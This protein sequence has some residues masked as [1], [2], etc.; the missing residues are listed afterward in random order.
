MQRQKTIAKWLVIILL[1]TVAVGAYIMYDALY[2]GE[3]GGASADVGTEQPDPSPSEPETPDPDPPFYTE[4]P[5]PTQ[6]YAG[7]EVAHAGGEGDEAVLGAVFTA[8]REYVFFSSESEEYDCRGSG[9]YVAV[10]SEGALIAVTRFADAGSAFGGAKLTANGVAAAVSGEESGTLFLFD[11]SGGV[12]GEASVPLFESAFLLLAD[13][14]LTVFYSDGVRLGVC[15][16]GEGL[17]VDVSPFRLGGAYTV[18][19]GFAAGGSFVLAADNG[20]DVAV[21][22]YTHASGFINTKTYSQTSFKQ[23]VPVAGEDGAAFC[24]LGGRSDGVLLSVIGADGTEESAAVLEGSAD[25]ALFGDG[26]SLTLV[27]TGLTETYCRHLDLI[28]SVTTAF[29]VGDVLAVRESGGK[30]VILS[31]SEDGRATAWL[32]EDGGGFLS[33]AECDGGEGNA[34]A[35]FYGGSLALVLSSRS[36]DG[37]FFENFGGADAYFVRIPL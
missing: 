11:K 16:V 2:V 20:Q 5:R 34:A 21:I 23:I 4:L 27:R 31:R 28:S 35:E 36:R 33:V 7:I 30:R 37:I 1:C 18:R 17:S 9:V 10:Y 32:S 15:T 8:D 14:D 29:T 19:E 12:K 6:T 3:G 24:L 13:G 25:A 26:T 22:T